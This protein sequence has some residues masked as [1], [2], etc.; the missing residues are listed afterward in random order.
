MESATWVQILDKAVCF[1][2]QANAF[3]KYKHPTVL[4]QW[5]NSREDLSS[6]ALVDQL[7]EKENFKYKPT[8]LSFKIDLVSHPACGGGV[9]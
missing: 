4:C 3:R 5:V 9:G 6:L 7:V 1:S 8:V 2:F